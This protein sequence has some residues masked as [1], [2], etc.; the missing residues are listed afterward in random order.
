MD[1]HV[2]SDRVTGTISVGSA[3]AVVVAVSLLS[4][5]ET[6]AR[7][8]TKTAS[9]MGTTIESLSP[10][11]NTASALPKHFRIDSEGRIEECRVDADKVSCTTRLNPIPD[12][13][14]SATGEFT[15]TLSGLTVTGTLTTQE[16]FHMT[17]PS[18]RT[19]QRRSGPATYEFSLDGTVV[20]GE[21]LMQTDT[22]N[23]GKC[24]GEGS[25]SGRHWGG[26]G[27]GTW[28]PIT[29]AAGR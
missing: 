7:D 23:T 21:G 4:A 29:D 19:V 22:V 11:T 1:R 9:S 13:V 10:A 15:G 20:M 2:V 18:C 28:S 26:Q 17:D 27:T 8:T 14:E 3:L 6:Q 16:T 25:Y 24:P 5:C 12:N